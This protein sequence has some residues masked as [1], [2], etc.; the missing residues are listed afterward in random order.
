VQLV[1]LEGELVLQLLDPGLSLGERLDLRGLT[2]GG[3]LGGVDSARG[4]RREQ[5]KNGQ[6]RR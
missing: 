6:Q 3:L 1:V 2:S 4:T 5:A